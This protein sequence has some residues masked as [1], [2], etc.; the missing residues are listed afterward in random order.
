MELASY[1][2]TL[3]L[4]TDHPT[5]L[6]QLRG[7][8][9]FYPEPEVIDIAPQK[10]SP[11]CFV[12]FWVFFSLTQVQC[13]YCRNEAPDYS[14]CCR[15]EVSDSLVCAVGIRHQNTVITVGIRHQN[16]VLL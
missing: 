2:E 7:C 12:L 8:E 16:V 15:N 4:K 9:V 6:C 13:F 5:L 10:N 3:W 14:G 11:A 1:A